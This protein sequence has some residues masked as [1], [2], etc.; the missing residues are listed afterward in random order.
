MASAAARWAG[1]HTARQPRGRRRGE[2]WMAT[3]A[4]PAAPRAGRRR[5]AGG[6]RRAG[7]DTPAGPSSGHAVPLDQRQPDAPGAP[8]RSRC[9]TGAAA[10]REEAVLGGEPV[11]RRRHRSCGAGRRAPARPARR[12]PDGSARRVG[13]AGRRRAPRRTLPE[14]AERPLD[15]AFALGVAGLT[16]LDLGAVVPGELQRRRVQLE[17]AAL[18]PAE[19]AHPVGAAQRDPAAAS[20]SRRCPRRCAPG[21]PTP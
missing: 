8:R 16:G 15:L 14:V 4:G 1:S 12:G 13:R 19:R 3:S 20:K 6:P 2:R 10:T 9:R 18:R 7:R 11:D 21:R 5:P 17:P